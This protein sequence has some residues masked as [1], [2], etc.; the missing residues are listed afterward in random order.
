MARSC[1]NGSYVVRASCRLGKV[2]ALVGI[3]AAVMLL[4][5][6]P[7]AQFRPKLRTFR[8]EDLF[9]IKQIGTTAWSPNGSHVAIE[10][11]NRIRSLG[12]DYANEIDLLDLKSRTMR[13]LSS[14]R[15]YV[16]WLF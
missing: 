5:N 3:C 16:R 6:V 2:F 8:P 11:A 7:A 1:L 12:S 14:Q 10:E 15:S 13:R 4:H 9:R